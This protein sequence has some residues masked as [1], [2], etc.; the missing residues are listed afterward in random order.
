MREDRLRELREARQLTQKE[1]AD[2][3]GVSDQQIYRYETGKSDP[4]AEVLARIAKELEV[5]ADF[6]LGLVDTPHSHYS[7]EDLK[8][9]ERKLLAA[10]KRGDWPALMRVIA[11]GGKNP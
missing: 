4:T 5:S 11:Q 2:R 8:P 9:D 10:Y 7:D 1:L 3:I 6:L